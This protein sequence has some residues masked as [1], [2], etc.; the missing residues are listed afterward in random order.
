[1]GI[2]FAFNPCLTWGSDENPG[3]ELDRS[4]SYALEVVS[5]ASLVAGPAAVVATS[6]WLSHEELAGTL[7]TSVLDVPS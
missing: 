6:R 2:T 4:I 5:V 3:P 1:M 7:S